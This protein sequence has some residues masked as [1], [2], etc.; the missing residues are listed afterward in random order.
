MLK[1]R[2]HLTV[3]A[4]DSDRIVLYIH[5]QRAES[6]LSDRRA[7]VAASDQRKHVTTLRLVGTPRPA[8]SL[9][10]RPGSYGIERKRVAPG[11]HGKFAGITFS[12]RN[13]HEKELAAA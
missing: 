9:G 1:L 8:A 2:P 10:L 3:L 5:R 13:T 12:H 7:T 11:E 4:A 6:M